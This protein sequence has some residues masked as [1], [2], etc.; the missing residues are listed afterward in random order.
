MEA[1]LD[2]EN[3][4]FDPLFVVVKGMQDKQQEVLEAVR[5]ISEMGLKTTGGTP[6]MFPTVAPKKL[7]V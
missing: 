3:I 5:Q 6:A 7:E 1:G 4:L 2:Q